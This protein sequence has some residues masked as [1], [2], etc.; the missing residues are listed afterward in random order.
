MTGA[1]GIL[2]VTVVMAL[3]GFFG[4]AVVLSISGVTGPVLAMV[5]ALTMSATGVAGVMCAAGVLRAPL[6]QLSLV[7]RCSPCPGFCSY[8]QCHS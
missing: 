1:T 4:V 6:F 2:D 8:H 3:R 7:Y 5:A